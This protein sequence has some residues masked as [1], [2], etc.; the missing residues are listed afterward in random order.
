MPNLRWRQPLRRLIEAPGAALVI[1]LVWT[2][3][4]WTVPAAAAD[5]PREGTLGT[6]RT[7]SVDAVSFPRVGLKSF[8]QTH[9]KLDRKSTRL[10]S[11]H[12]I[13]SYAVFCLKKKKE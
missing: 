11:S 6:S 1:L 12:Q 13:I 3:L 2:L 10:N 4:V 5:C 8:A 9:G 7:M